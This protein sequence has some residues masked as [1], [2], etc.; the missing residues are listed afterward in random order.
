MFDLIKSVG[1][2]G[3]LVVIAGLFLYVYVSDRNYYKERDERF[4]RSQDEWY[5]NSMATNDKLA[6]IIES[7]SCTV[8]DYGKTLEKHSED[9][10]MSFA[11]L[12]KKIDKVDRQMAI[13]SDSTKELATKEMAEEIHSEIKELK[14]E[15][16]K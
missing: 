7:N 10:S 15:V 14:K 4:H 13:L 6:K 11:D 9:S 1:D 3:V 12:G 2:Y 5:K 16:K 8:A